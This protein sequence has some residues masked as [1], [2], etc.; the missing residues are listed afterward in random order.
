MSIKPTY[1]HILANA[2]LQNPKSVPPPSNDDTFFTIYG[3]D[4]CGY[5][6]AA[7]KYCEDS[8][9]KFK[10][11]SFRDNRPLRNDF[12]YRYAFGHSTIPMVFQGQKFIG[13]Y[14]Q[15]KKL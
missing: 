3:E 11:I 2:G 4:W 12:A 15:L 13:G 7:R 6:S 1:Q 5:T 14:E 8:G 9:K 10:Y